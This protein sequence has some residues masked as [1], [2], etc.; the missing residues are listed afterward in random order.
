MKTRQVC[1]VWCGVMAATLAHPAA[2][3]EVGRDG[4][5][6]VAPPQWAPPS[7]T[8][9]RSSTAKADYLV[10]H[11]WILSGGQVSPRE[12]MALLLEVDIDAGLVRAAVLPEDPA[13]PKA[14]AATTFTIDEVRQE[15]TLLTLRATR[16]RQHGGTHTLQLSRQGATV[17]IH[18]VWRDQHGHETRAAIRVLTRIARIAIDDDVD[19]IDGL[20]RRLD[21][22]R[23]LG[24]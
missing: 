15:G 3:L 7:S 22:E 9:T 4:R 11:Q 10:G 12:R 21:A 2:A 23:R 6:S 13:A 14:A 24:G 17:S 19:G 8:S 5:V 18:E 20:A 1:L 16:Q